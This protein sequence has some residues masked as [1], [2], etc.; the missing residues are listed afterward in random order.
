MKT[1][2]R[3]GSKGICVIPARGGSQR[4]PRKN[5]KP[6]FGVPIICYA[7]VTAMKSRLFEH[8]VVST[9]DPEI[10]HVA[11]FTGAEVHKREHGLAENHVGTQVVAADAM[12]AYRCTSDQLACCLY[13]TTPLLRPDDLELA[14]G[15]LQPTKGGRP[16]YVVSVGAN[17]LRDAGA[18]YMGLACWFT[19]KMPLWTC[20]TT[21]YVLPEERCQD[22]NTPDDWANAEV[23]YE[24]ILK[25][26]TPC[27]SSIT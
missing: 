20:Q 4:I 14:A 17:P 16:A 21:L 19:E 26:L 25:G 7:I 18:F 15:L 5:V 11:Q 6:F 8:V 23:K 10:A 9:E 27:D 22:I 13:P 12:R 2:S 3:V 1:V 24:G